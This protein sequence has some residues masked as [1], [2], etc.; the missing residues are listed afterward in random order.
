MLPENY[1]DSSNIDEEGRCRI[2]GGEPICQ[3]LGVVRY[4]VPV[5]DPRFG[6]LFRCPNNPVEKDRERQDRLRRFSNLEAYADKVF[7]NFVINPGML[8]Q[9]E[10]HSLTTALRVVEKFAA[11]PEGWV[12]LEGGY[13]CGKTH[14][15]AAVGN[16]RLAQGDLVLFLTV[17]DLLDYLRNTFGPASEIGYDELFDRVRNVPLLIL[18]DLG[19]ENASS[20]AQE[21]LF[22]LLNFRYSRRLPTVVTT[23]VQMDALDP[24]IRSRLLDQ[25]FVHR[26]TITAPDYR[27]AIQNQRD[28]LLSSLSLYKEKTFENFDTRHYVTP[29]EHR[30][31]DMA[32][33]IAHS[34]AA[35]PQGWLVFLGPYGSGKTHLAAA[36]A[37]YQQQQG[38]EVMFITVPDLLDYLR[39]AYSPDAP[40][41]FDRR[42]QMVRNAAFLVL[43]DLGT[44]NSSAW[45]REKLFQI[46]DYRYVTRRPTVI[47]TARR[48]EEI[49]KRI[50]SRLID[51][52]CCTT[53]AITVPGYPLRRKRE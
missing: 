9:A 46:M 15:A 3:G 13:G 40:V 39:V 37:H 34:Y 44:E 11:K 20:W 50:Q 33:Q 43:D 45:A 16:A 24:R 31:L 42:F 4:D 21:K 51:D 29:D 35:S 26:T 32:L 28:T 5:D 19:A 48:L 6:K 10:A 38:V 41:S 52:Q 47:T 7:D 8:T 53:F 30:N 17:P 22:Q 49:D 25:D 27:S 14:L 18:D 12:L 2:C 23:N 36:I 1:P